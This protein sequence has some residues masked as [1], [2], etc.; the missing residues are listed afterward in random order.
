M[1]LDQNLA[2]AGCWE[3]NLNEFEVFVTGHATGAA[4]EVYL[5]SDMISHYVLVVSSLRSLS[6]HLPMLLYGLGSAGLHRLCRTV[7]HVDNAE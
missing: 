7:L 4:D 1:I 6:L 2:R 3:L 5:F